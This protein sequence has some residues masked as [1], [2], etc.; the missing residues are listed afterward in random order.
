MRAA[1]SLTE[2]DDLP[3]PPTVGFRR[4]CDSLFREAFH[5][6]TELETPCEDPPLPRGRGHQALASD[7]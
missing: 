2:P 7:R 6:L 4:V 3:V 5:A 1:M